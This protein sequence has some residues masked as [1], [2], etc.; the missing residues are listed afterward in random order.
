MTTAIVTVFYPKE[1]NIINI[2]NISRQVDRLIICDN[3]PY[4]NSK[5]FENINENCIYKAFCKN[6]GLSKA[7]NEILREHTF[8][9][10][11]EE[12]IVFFDQDSQIDEEHI[13]ILISS[14]EKIE[15]YRKIGAL[16]PVFYNQS[17]GKI[18]VPRLKEKILNNVFKVSSIITSSM[19]TKYG[20][21][22]KINFWNDEVFLDM[23]D[24]DICWRLKEKGYDCFLTNDIIMKHSL[25]IGEKKI[26]LMKIRIGAPFREYYQIRDSQYLLKKEY[27]PLKYKIRFLLMLT[28]RSL[29]HILFLDNAKE[30]MYYI[31]LGYRDFKKNIHGELK[32]DK[33]YMDD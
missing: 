13:E 32:K 20:I 4:D 3:T 5:K 16:G 17:N 15:K 18:E 2:Q 28:I 6:L 1:T 8:K 22:R 31:N 9:W 7:F 19:L 11:D 30:R 29:L 12:Y 14:F 26:L 25:G 33:L 21:L 24:W 27:V 23:A 10:T